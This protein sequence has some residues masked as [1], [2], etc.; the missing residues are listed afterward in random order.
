MTGSG[1]VASGA[2][3]AT[4]YNAFNRR[5]GVVYFFAGCSL[6]GKTVCKKI[7]VILNNI[8]EGTILNFKFLK[9]WGKEVFI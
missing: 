8:E 7:A 2:G 3:A 4:P 9:N 6:S 5:G 1:A